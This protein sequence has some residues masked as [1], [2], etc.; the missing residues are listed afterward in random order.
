MR[1]KTPHA[2]SPRVPAQR[3]SAQGESAPKARPKG[4]VDG[5]PVNSP[6]LTD[7]AMGGRRRLHQPAI[8]SAGSRRRERIQANPDAPF[9]EQMHERLGREV[10][11]ARLP[12]KASKLQVSANRTPNRHRWAR[13]VSSGAGENSGEGTRQTSTVT[14]GEGA[15][16]Y[17]NPLRG[18]RKRAAVTRWLRLFTKNTALCQHESGR[19]GCDACPVPEG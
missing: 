5:K 17:V 10:V 1:V 18:E 15:P 12:R 14:S 3:Q 8:G 16:V 6:V 13:R 2:E 4:V 9:R 11:N 7:T 19:I